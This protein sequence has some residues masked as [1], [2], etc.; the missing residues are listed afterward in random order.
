M[1]QENLSVLAYSNGFT[2]WNYKHNGNLGQVVEDSAFFIP[3]NGILNVGDMI[4]ISAGRESEESAFGFFAG[5]SPE[6]VKI[7]IIAK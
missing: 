3:V 1:K 4:F 7:R 2:L 6:G 5:V